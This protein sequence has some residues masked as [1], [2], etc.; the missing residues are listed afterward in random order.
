MNA[1]KYCVPYVYEVVHWEVDDICVVLVSWIH[2]IA[3]NVVGESYADLSLQKNRVASMC[4]WSSSVKKIRHR[5]CQSE[6]VA[7]PCLW[8]V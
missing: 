7:R 1:C 4:G 6:C 3:N 5:H 8:L 2:C